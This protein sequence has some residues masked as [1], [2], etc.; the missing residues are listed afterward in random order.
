MNAEGGRT[1]TCACSGAGTEP[2]VHEL[3]ALLSQYRETLRRAEEIPALLWLPT[4]AAGTSPLARWWR[5]PRLTWGTSFFVRYHVSRSVDLLCRT[6]AA[7]AAVGELDGTGVRER[8]MVVDFR[9]SLQPVQLRWVVLGAVLALLL[10]GRAVVSQL[11][12][13]PGLVDFG[14]GVGTPGVDRPAELRDVFDGLAT[15]ASSLTGTSLFALVDSLSDA[16][17]VELAV[18]AASLSAAGYVV[19]RPLTTAFRL[20]RVLFNLAEEPSK[21]LCATP[22]TWHVFRSRGLYRREE[23]F[24]AR[25]GALPQAREKP[26][27]LAI[28]TLPV[29]FVF[30]VFMSICLTAE[31]M[32]LLE[33]GLLAEEPELILSFGAL[34][35]ALGG[36]RVAWLVAAHRCRRRQLPEPA[37]PSAA[38]LP[39]TSRVVDVRPVLETA[40]L[41]GF[42]APVLLVAAVRQPAA[43]LLAAPLI[44]ARYRLGRQLSA[45]RA[46][47][48]ASAGAPKLRRSPR[49]LTASAALTALTPIAYVPWVGSARRSSARGLREP[50]VVAVLVG[51]LA[52]FLILPRIVMGGAD[53]DFVLVLL[54]LPLSYMVAAGGAQAVHNTLVTRYG[55]PLAQGIAPPPLLGGP[56][57]WRR[58]LGSHPVTEGPASEAA[59]SSDERSTAVPAARDAIAALG[60]T[61]HARDPLQGRPPPHQRRVP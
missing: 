8:Q 19:V 52:W 61:S 54:G 57:R 29:L 50:G 14:S 6:Y 42:V 28:S 3:T 16:T 20:K 53:Q 31:Q 51:L 36:A 5:L 9:E 26:L 59:R 30:W 17:P 44:G 34:V 40:I 27:D 7:R 55:L 39:S 43:M 25:V 11:A 47:A 48:A 46:E 58:F 13:S 1:T 4:R 41:G 24:F 12:R 22:A 10:L 23:R 49:A 37:G 18:L 15:I 45:L 33:E 56:R 21:V 38:L 60:A 35:A 2:Y 32:G